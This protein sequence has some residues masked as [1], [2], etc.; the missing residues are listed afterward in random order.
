MSESLEKLTTLDKAVVVAEYLYL[1]ADE[2]L[3][4]YKR[5]LEWSKEHNQD[6]ECMQRGYD[7]EMA[8]C[9]AYHEA[10][11]MLKLYNK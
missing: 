3:S 2:E 7:R 10:L 8:V 4:W 1:K 9:N 11:D 5:Q 6:V